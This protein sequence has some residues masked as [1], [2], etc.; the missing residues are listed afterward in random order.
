M[1]SL[2]KPERLSITGTGLEVEL[3][4]RSNV[5]VRRSGGDIKVPG[6]NLRQFPERVALLPAERF[7]SD[8]G[9]GACTIRACAALTLPITSPKTSLPRPRS[10]SD[11]RAGCSCSTGARGA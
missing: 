6:R 3:M 2:E 7:S 9:R 1:R 8:T 11:R 10:P 4:T 5:S